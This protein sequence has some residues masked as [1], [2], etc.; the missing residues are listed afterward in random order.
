MARVKKPYL[1]TKPAINLVEYL[2]SMV[3]LM[4]WDSEEQIHISRDYRG[5]RGQGPVF[6]RISIINKGWLTTGANV[7]EYIEQHFNFTAVYR[8]GGRGPPSR[9]P[10]AD[11]RRAA[12]HPAQRRQLAVPQA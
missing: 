10:A 7:G 1:T 12:D 8:G 3:E 4:G 2:E 9:D 5:V 6:Y 11:A